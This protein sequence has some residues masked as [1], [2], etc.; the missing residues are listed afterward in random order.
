MKGSVIVK[1]MSTDGSR[2]KMGDND[3]GARGQRWGID[4]ASSDCC[5]AFAL[6]ESMTYERFLVLPGYSC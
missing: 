6:Y 5:L 1:T 3:A 4:C 2:L